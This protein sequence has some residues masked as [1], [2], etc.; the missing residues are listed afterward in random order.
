MVG[1]IRRT[2]LR[3]PSSIAMVGENET[4][5]RARSF[6]AVDAGVGMLRDAGVAP[7]DVV[8][9]RT[10]RV[11]YLPVALLSVWEVGA[12]AAIV[13]STLPTARVYDCD[14]VV[15]PAW[16]LALDGPEP[17]AVTATGRPAGGTAPVQGDDDP[18]H[19]LFT[20]GTT[21]R[22]A[23]VEV[24]RGAISR[25]LGWYAHTFRP[26]PMDRIGLLAGLGHDPMLRDTLVP[27]ICGG[28]LAIP[29]ADVFAGPD[30]LLAFIRRARL[31]ILHCTPGLLDLILAAHTVEGRGLESL[32]LV[33]SAG[34]SLSVGTVRRLRRAC[35]AVIV[36]AY[37]STE[38]PQIASCEVVSDTWPRYV[39]LSDRAP[40][41]VGAGVGGAELLIADATGRP[42]AQRGEIVVRSP[43]LATGY[44]AGTGASERFGRDPAGVPG[45][46]VYRSGDLGWRRD[47]GS[48]VLMGRLDREMSVNGHRVAPEEIEKAA[49]R[50][51]AV[52]RAAAGRVSTPDGDLVGL[53]VVLTSPSATDARSLRTFL[54][55]RLPRFVAPTRIRVVPELS[56]DRNHKA[57]MADDTEPPDPH[58]MSTPDIR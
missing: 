30:R 4:W 55:E 13:D 7:G 43:N 31:T 36:N 47:D 22:P 17:F 5:S 19:V 21:G 20:S 1:R 3:D 18:S 15:E 8:V 32:R 58:P 12:V 26:G 33:V 10:R 24:S 48:I 54:L 23:A 2:C 40:I 6:A 29:P 49:L 50:H 14:Q 35:G 44:L 28:V 45:Y 37:G 16:K 52:L 46:R 39:R 51:P 34:A 57:A 9:V 27:L 56:L 11:G 53:S 42:G 25:A 38:T 41:G